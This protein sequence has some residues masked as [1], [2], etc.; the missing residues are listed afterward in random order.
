MPNNKFNL[1]RTSNLSS[2]LE[3]VIITFSWLNFFE[4]HL[5][6]KRALTTLISLRCT[7]SVHAAYVQ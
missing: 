3:A 1:E 4:E 5:I 6:V 2:K 7:G